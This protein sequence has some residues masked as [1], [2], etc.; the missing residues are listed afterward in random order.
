[1]KKFKCPNCDF[2]DVVYDVVKE[3]SWYC[4]EKE[5]EKET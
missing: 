5:D 2:E 3:H 1:M 4:G